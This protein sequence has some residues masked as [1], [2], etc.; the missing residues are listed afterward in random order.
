VLKEVLGHKEKKG[1]LDRRNY[2]FGTKLRGRGGSVTLEDAAEGDPW[3][4]DPRRGERKAEGLYSGPTRLEA[5][6]GFRESRWEIRN[7][8]KVMAVR[9]T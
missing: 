7:G 6:L 2:H 5:N 8:E 9:R 3:R 4:G 1:Y